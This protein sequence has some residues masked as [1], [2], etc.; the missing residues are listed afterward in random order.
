MSLPVLVGLAGAVIAAVTT[1]MLAGRWVRRLRVGLIA[2]AAATLALTIALVAESLGF[3]RGFDQLTFRTVQLTA[4]VLAPLWISWGLIEL[5]AGHEAVRFASRLVAGAATVVASVI[6]ATDPLFSRTFGKGWP[7]ARGHFQPVATD[8]IDAVQGLAVVVVLAG[9]I[10]A[11]ARATR[12][13]SG[14]PA[15]AGV[16]AASVAVPAAAAMRLTLPNRAG[17]PLFGVLAAVLV[18]VGMTR[19]KEQTGTKTRDADLVVAGDGEQP[20]RDNGD[21]PGDDGAGHGSEPHDDND[22]ADGDATADGDQAEDGDVAEGQYEL[23]G[24][25]GPL[26]PAGQ[27]SAWDPGA[28]DHGGPDGRAYLADPF[29]DDG[30]AAAGLLPGTDGG[31]PRADGVP[32]GAAGSAQG[33]GARPYGRILIFTLLDE[34]VDDFDRLAEQAAEEV[35]VAEPDTLVYVIHLVPNAPMQ[36]I[37]YEIYRDQTAFEFHE[38]QPYMQR[39]VAER[40]SCVLATNVIELRLKYAKVA[41]L[42]S[43]QAAAPAPPQA[44]AQATAGSAWQAGPSPAAGP[45]SAGGLGSGAGLGPGA[46]SVPAGGAARA[47]GP[48]PRLQP[49]AADPYPQGARGPQ[50]SPR[51]QSPPVRAQYQAPSSYQDQQPYQDQ[52]LYQDT[53]QYTG[54]QYGTG[55]YPAQ[56]PYPGGQAPYPGG[57]GQHAGGPAPYPGGEYGGAGGYPEQRYPGEPMGDSPRTDPRASSRPAAPPW[58][59]PLR[60][61]TQ[62]GDPLRGDPLRGD[63]QRG[64]PL[65]GDYRRGDPLGGDPLRPD[66]LRPDPLR[67][68]LGRPDPLRSD[69]P[70]QDPL[71]RDPLTDP[72]RPDSWRPGP[73]PNDRWRGDPGD[74]RR[75]D[76]WRPGPPPDEW[77]PDDRW[78]DDRRPDEW[79][80]DEWRPDDSWEPGSQHPGQPDQPRP[81]RRRAPSAGRHN[82]SG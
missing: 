76:S 29:A 58:P 52:Q 44:P 34:R 17:Y 21:W 69:S 45:G 27:R 81:G 73:P 11:I 5:V 20:S 54:S 12:D 4:G 77:R 61:D 18:W 43:P 49:Q 39:F 32:A 51:F 66:P 70:R 59:D 46:G 10:L 48:M 75:T 80:S 50:G 71:R 37:F 36:R 53:G 2:W 38:N 55:Q 42:P 26:D 64:D 67:P 65:R 72:R 14:R 30:L 28:Q 15:L 78:Q 16:L 68:D 7:S 74:S 79:R 3:A 1:G 56:S 9:V 82:G 8:A 24:Q 31:V 35:R 13:T 33:R 63:P 41:P 22:V 25:R 40:R 6:L 62:R 23:Y 57:Q 60:G 19:S 47:S